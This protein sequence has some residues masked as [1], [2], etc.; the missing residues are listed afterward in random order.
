[1]FYRLIYG[2]SRQNQNF[3]PYFISKSPIHSAAFFSSCGLLLTCCLVNTDSFH[4]CPR[5]IPFCDMATS[6]LQLFY[7]VFKST[8]LNYANPWRN[9]T[10]QRF[11]RVAE[12][13]ELNGTN[14]KSDTL[15]DLNTG[16]PLFA[17]MLY[18]LSYGVSRQN[19][20]FNPYMLS[21]SPIHSIAFLCSCRRS[22][23]CCVVN[24]VYFDNC[25]RLISFCNI[26]TSFLWLL[27]VVSSSINA[28]K[29]CEPLAILD[30]PKLRKGSI[31]ERTQRHN[32]KIRL[33]LGFEPSSSA[34]QTDALPPMLRCQPAEPE[35]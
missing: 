11:V 13:K 18:W 21:K 8:L 19:Q 25:P 22:L 7:V 15:Y 35:F 31:E 23:T 10:F 33:L 2:V 6:C 27:Y 32:W 20:N 16:P 9:W 4:S 17:P 24:S 30:L 34:C 29:L 28:I 1:M 26:A 5:L 3:N 14:K 12:K